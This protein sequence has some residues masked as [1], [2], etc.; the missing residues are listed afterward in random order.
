MLVDM[1]LVDLDLCVVLPVSALDAWV[2]ADPSTRAGWLAGTAI[3]STLEVAGVP[4]VVF[5]RER[6][7]PTKA[8]VVLE[9]RRKVAIAIS[10][11]EAAVRAAIDAPASTEV[12]A[13]RAEVPSALLVMGGDLA[14]ADIAGGT[15]VAGPHRM[16]DLAPGAYRVE[17]RT[18][19]A[20]GAPGFASALVYQPA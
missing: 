7:R 1:D 4:G 8:I 14:H 11:A 2:R 9:P 13:E 17:R 10:G 18:I 19:G 20:P 15:P 12:L 16:V 3:A 6:P 5:R